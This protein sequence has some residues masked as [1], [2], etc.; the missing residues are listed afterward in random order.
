MPNCKRLPQIV[1]NVIYVILIDV[2]NHS[3]LQGFLA[4]NGYL[5]T[6]FEKSA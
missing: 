5:S 2:L 4:E 6:V 3:V 1:H